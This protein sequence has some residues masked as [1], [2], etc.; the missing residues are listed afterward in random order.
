MEGLLCV[1]CSVKNFTFK[2]LHA[3]PEIIK[4]SERGSVT[5]STQYVQK[6]TLGRCGPWGL[7]FLEAAVT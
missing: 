1:R 4:Q 7:L 2:K 6:D 5:S 3:T